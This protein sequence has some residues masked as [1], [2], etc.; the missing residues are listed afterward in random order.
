MQSCTFY[1]Y[2]SNK[3]TTFAPEINYWRIE[4]EELF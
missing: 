4:S 1:L 2:I 3:S